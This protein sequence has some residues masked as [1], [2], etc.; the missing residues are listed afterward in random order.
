MQTWGI[1][2]GR[3]VRRTNEV[4]YW[5]PMDPNQAGLANQFGKLQGLQ[6]IQPPLR[7]SFSPYLTTGVRFNPE[8][9]AQKREWLRNGGADVKWGVNE[10]FTLDATLIPDFGQVISDNV[11]NNL[12]AYE[13]Q[14]Q[15]NRPFFT[16]GTELF[17]KSGLFYSRRIGAI[18][19][20]YARVT[21]L[22]AQRPEYAIL[23]NPSVTQLYN[24][25]KFSGRTKKKLG[26]GVFNAITAPMEARLENTNT[27]KDTVVQTEPLTNYN[28]V[29]LDQALRGRSFVTFTNTN[30]MR[31]GVGRD[32][33][34]SA[35]DWGLYDKRTRYA[36][37]GTVR[38]SKIFGHTPINSLP[39]FFKDTVREMGQLAL[40]PYDGYA[41]RLRFAKVSGK[42]RFNAQVNVESDTYDPNDLGILFAPNEVQYRGGVSW[43]QVKPTRNF[44]N[45]TYS[46]TATLTHLYK[47]YTYGNFEL[48]ASGFWIFKNFWDARISV[49]GNPRPQK[50]FFDLRTPGA[51]LERPASWYL[52]AGGS[53]DSRKRLY[54]S[55]ALFTGNSSFDN[56]NFLQ[57]DLGARYRFSNKFTLQVDA[58]R[59]HDRLDMGYAFRRESNRTPI[60][61]YRDY[62]MLSTTFSGIYNFTP[63]MNLTFRSRH[64]WNGVQYLSFFNTDADGNHLA[65]PFINGADE[66]VNFYNLD[67]FFTWDFRLG[68]RIIAGWK[69]RL[70]NDVEID[71]VVHKGYL[72]NFNQVLRV[73][74]GNEL[75][76]KVIYFLDYNQLRKKR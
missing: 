34:V 60:A 7:L 61:G 44:I 40:V 42:L 12:T 72:R 23:S 58:A 46:L 62:K 4:S 9:G 18:P 45:Y 74:H 59:Q 30:V 75:T 21:R 71:G 15:E 2:F 3:Q 48:Q 69:N 20:G 22:T 26:I 53:T 76:L 17:N 35:L 16:E 49:G 31:Q 68:S 57:V 33:N 54:V 11:I 64:Y 32:A 36:V 6:N 5:N 8:V 73:P 43:H 19:G 66:N 13:Q 39:V 70:S 1:Q 27:G 63:R 29:V 14:F 38:Y 67:A 65:R 55:Y 41:S 28:I 25:T 24:A 50:D 52:V 10:S 56:S 47:P 37:T 51:V